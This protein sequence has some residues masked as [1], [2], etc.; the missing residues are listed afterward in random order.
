MCLVLE[1]HASVNMG[2]AEYQAHQLAEELSRRDGVRVTYLARTAPKLAIDQYE[3]RAIGNPSGFRRRAVIF[4]ARRLGRALMAL[5]PNVIYQRAKQSYTGVCAHY[6]RHARIPMVFHVANE[7]DV[8][9]RWLRGQLSSNT[10]L[11]LL[12]VAA[13]NWGLKRASH[14]VVQTRRQG[15]LLQGRFGRDP[16]ALVRNFQPLPDV[17]PPK[18]SHGLRVLWVA[19]VKEAKRPE[20]YLELAERMAR[21]SGIEFWMVGRPSSHRAVR[22]TMMAI[23][24]SKNLRYF[25][26]LSLGE[27][28]ALMSDADVF[29]NTSSFEGF[30]NTFIQAWARGAIVTSLDVDIDGGME[31][32]GIGYCA[33]QLARLVDVIDML[34]ASTQMRAEIAQRAFAYAWKEHSLANLSV[35]ADLVINAART[36]G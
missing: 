30:P 32:Q 9:R 23:H 5:S 20:L 25:G 29:V 10:P 31:A 4:D 28:N 21:R 1:H 36:R 13:G 18:R 15:H 19:N 24:Q 35:L 22:A 34:G 2:G 12:E 6:A 8:D 11:E 33:G 14:V 16:T 27:V 7:P 26:E 17:L 3:V